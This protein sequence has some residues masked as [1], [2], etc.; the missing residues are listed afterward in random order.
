[1]QKEHSMTNVFVRAVLLLFVLLSA[2]LVYIGLESYTSISE[3]S[4]QTEHTRTAVSFLFN[5]FRASRTEDITYENIG[6]IPAI[7]IKNQVGNQ[8]YKDYIYYYKG[9][10]YEL[11]I[12]SEYQA[13]VNYGDKIVEV[14]EFSIQQEEKEWKISVNHH[15]I[16]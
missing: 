15:R 3:K 7:A 14:E 12:D 11:Y 8:V 4:V 5:K 13:D 1:M 2:L 9:A 16:R 6:D 10:I